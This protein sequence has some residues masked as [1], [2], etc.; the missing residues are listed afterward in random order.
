MQTYRR[1]FLLDICTKISKTNGKKKKPRTSRRLRRRR[2]RGGGVC[3]C[4][5]RTSNS[6]RYPQLFDDPGSVVTN[7]QTV[8]PGRP[9]VRV[10]ESRLRRR[11]VC[12]GRETIL[13]LL[14]RLL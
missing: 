13:T 9:I 7:S 1:V 3:V 4:S 10:C 12:Y 11:D 6:I 8:S 5:S 14:L 2:R